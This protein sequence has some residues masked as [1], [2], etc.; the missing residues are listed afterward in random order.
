VDTIPLSCQALRLRKWR[1]RRPRSMIRVDFGIPMPQNGLYQ[2]IFPILCKPAH[3]SNTVRDPPER[4]TSFFPPIQPGTTVL[5][6]HNVQTSIRPLLRTRTQCACA[7]AGMTLL[8]RPSPGS[9]FALF[10]LF[11]DHHDYRATSMAPSP[12]T[13]AAFLP[14]LFPCH[15]RCLT[16]ISAHQPKLLTSSASITKGDRPYIIMPSNRRPSFPID[17]HFPSGTEGLLIYAQNDS[18]STRSRSG[19]EGKRNI[20][21]EG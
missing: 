14:P 5:S 12:P 11:H 21:Y 16:T 2:H 9:P 3:I 6:Y 20:I 17:V 1:W 7:D 10:T 4:H 18:F 19:V 8:C 15:S 13:C